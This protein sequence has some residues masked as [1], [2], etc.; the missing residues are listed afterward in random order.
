M[1][2][3]RFAAVSLRIKTNQ[4]HK[5]L[6]SKLSNQLRCFS[7]TNVG[8]NQPTALTKD[9][10]NGIQDATQLFMRHGIGMQKMKVIAKEAED[11]DTVVGRW[12]SMMEA[13]LG[14]QVHVLSGLGYTPDESGL[15]L[16]NQHL[17]TFVQSASPSIQEDLRVANRDLWRFVLSSSFNV[18]L[19]DIKKSEMNIVDARNAMHKV[20]MKMIEPAV[21]ES[22]ALK[23]AS[24]TSTGNYATDMAQKHQIVQ[25]ALVHDV[26]IGGEPSLLTEC[27]FE[28]GEKGYV[29]MQCVMAEHQSDPLI[30]QYISSAMMQVLKSAGIDMSEVRK[31]TEAMKSD[32]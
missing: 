12:Q 15:H 18:S 23:C 13:Y 19:E 27:G 9:M 14:T 17:A 20:S 24:L 3:S 4:A 29:S 30:T 32:S 1:L 16:Y 6:T 26:Y 5:R 25:E 10:A 21:L 8:L 31:A 22:I 2:L 7:S 11:V 28:S